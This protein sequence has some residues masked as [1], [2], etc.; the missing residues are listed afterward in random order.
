MNLPNINTD[1]KKVIINMDLYYSKP[2]DVRIIG[3]DAK[4]KNTVYFNRLANPG[5]AGAF[6]IDFPLPVSP[7]ELQIEVKPENEYD[8]FTY[9]IKSMGS[10]DLNPVGVDADEMDVE[11]IKFLRWFC[12]NASHLPAGEYRWPG[13]KP[14]IN[15]MD[16][17]V[18]SELGI[19]TTPARVDHNSG[20]HQIAREMFKTYTIPQRMV[21]GAHEYSHWKYDNTNEIFCDLN[22]LRICLGL[23]FPK[24]ECIYTFTNILND[25]H[26]SNNRLAEIVS[27]VQSFK[28]Q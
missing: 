15:Y 5:V 16:R 26:E 19:L 7:K 24:S 3:R 9:F 13:L 25:D 18:D 4:D 10:E 21:I 22:A 20:E 1:N 6:N 12:E 27:Y 11:Y 14:W 17:I 28:Q 23:G 8:K 2:A